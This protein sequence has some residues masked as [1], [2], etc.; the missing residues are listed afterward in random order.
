MFRALCRPATAAF[1]QAARPMVRPMA[2]I[3][4]RSFAAA[5]GKK[6]KM[7][8]GT[9]E[10]RYATALFMASGSKLEKVYGDMANLRA[11]MESSTDFKLLVETPGVDPE[12]KV[13]TLEAICKKAGADGAVVNF[14]KVL[15]ENKRI[16]SLSRVIDLFEA[17]YRAEKNLLL[18][19]VTS[20]TPL[21]SSEQGSVKK[22]MQQRA[23]AGSELIME[24]N[25]NPAIMGGLVVKMGEGVFDNS[26]ATRLERIQAQLMQPV[27]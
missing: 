8:D 13:A 3:A 23:G 6:P 5:V 19:K 21:S 27:S 15:V 22:A 10:G 1:S 11:M 26:V 7:E 18:C 16:S 25:V 14:L 2:P 4:T 24:Y 20:A 17:F 12:T 9:L